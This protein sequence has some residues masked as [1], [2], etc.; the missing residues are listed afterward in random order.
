MLCSGG[1]GC[2]DY[3]AL[4]YFTEFWCSDN[5]DPIERCFIQ[6]G[7]S[8]IFPC[9]LM[10][11]HVTSWNKKSSNKFRTDVASMCKLGFDIGLKDLGADEIK[12]VQQAV[13]NWSKNKEV[14]LEGDQYRLISP[15]DTESSHMAVNYVSKDK[16]KLLIT[17]FQDTN[18]KHSH[19]V[20]KD[21]KVKRNIRLPKLT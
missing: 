8:Q 1:S 17:F 4:K 7:F 10:C 14:I 9:K 6:W 19:V 18:Q 12:Y 13:S 3:G 5:T 2:C 21:L 16:K 20:Y 11:A 15:Y